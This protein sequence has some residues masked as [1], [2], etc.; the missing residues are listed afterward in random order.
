[1]GD[2]GTPM[3]DRKGEDLNNYLGKLLRVD[4]RQFPYRVPADNP[5]VGQ[6]NAKPEIWAY[7]LRRLWRFSFDTATQTLIGGDV[8]DKMQEEVDVITKGG[9][10]GWP[11][12]EGDSIRVKSNTINYSSFIP[13]IATYGRKEGICVMGGAVYRGKAIPALQ[14][15]YFFADL[16]GNLFALTKTAQGSWERKQLTVLNKPKDTFIIN[17]CNVDDNGEIYLLGA[18]NTKTGFK[19]MVYRLGKGY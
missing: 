5:F 16:N 2:N 14:G 7:G 15:R 13:P 9:N 11:I 1:V 19:G 10:Y 8:G 18:L 12:V 4:V 3:K 6:K 17:S